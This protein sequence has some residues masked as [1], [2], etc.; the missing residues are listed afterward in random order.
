M[1]LLKWSIAMPIIVVPTVVVLLV[2]ILLCRFAKRPVFCLL[3]FI[4]ILCSCSSIL[5]FVISGM[6]S[7][8]Y[9]GLILILLLEAITA[10]L[11]ADIVG[12]VIGLC[13]RGYNIVK[14]REQ[15]DAQS[16]SDICCEESDK[17]IDTIGTTVK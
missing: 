11:V 10:S 9:E 13:W 17:I 15:S 6:M 4:G 8:I 16:S 5:L 1:I 14:L 2:Q 3:P 7:N 12:W